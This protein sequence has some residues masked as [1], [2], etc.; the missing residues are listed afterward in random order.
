MTTKTKIILR[1]VGAAAAGVVVGMLL[2]PEKGTTTMR[3]VKDTAGGWA[4]QLGDLFTNAKSEVANL[5]NKAGRSASNAGSRFDNIS[6][7][8]S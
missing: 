8:Y 2:A 7:S 4:D 1:I 6:E 5:K 3:R